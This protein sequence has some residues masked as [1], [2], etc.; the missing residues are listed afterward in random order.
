M[1]ALWT[2]FASRR[3]ALRTP[4][5]G[6][7]TI[8]DARSR[9]WGKG[10]KLFFRPF[11]MDGPQRASCPLRS[12]KC[13]TALV[14][15]G[16]LLP[17]QAM[18]AQATASGQVVS[19]KPDAIAIT[20]YN[21]DL[22]MISELRTVNLPAGRSVISFEGVS[23]RMIP[24][25]AVLQEFSGFTL[26]QNFDFNLLG[27]GSL[28]ASAIGE[29]VTLI[30]TNPKTGREKE[31]RGRIVFG[32]RGVVID[33]GDSYEALQCS[34]MPERLVFDALPEDLLARPTLSI[35]VTAEKAGPQEIR[36]G[37]L[38]SG[39][40]W[41]A[42]YRFDLNES[43]K[44]GRLTGWLTI[45]NQTAVSVENADMSA[46]AGELQ[47]LAETRAP[48]S[49]TK[50]FYANCWRRGNTKTGI[51]T[52]I[53]GFTQS[54]ARRLEKDGEVAYMMAPSAEMA[55]ADEITV[56]GSRMMRQDMKAEREDLGDYKLYRTPWPTTVAAYQTKQIMFL[57]KEQ[58]DVE[59]IHVL[60]FGGRWGSSQI[61]PTT[62]EYRVDN[63]REG[64]LA[65]PL[66]QGTWRVL[67]PLQ[68][69]GR[70]YLGENWQDNL[71]VGLPVELEI[72]QSNDVV[73]E[74]VLV[75]DETYR[76]SRE[77]TVITR[78]FE[79]KIHNAS[80]E[81]VTVEIT[82]SEEDWVPPK[83]RRQSLQRVAD[84]QRPTWQLK[85]APGEIKTLRYTVR[86][87]E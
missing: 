51:R 81:T 24:Q 58:V 6:R 9:V 29:E 63:S 72:G 31:R 11:G 23:D 17:V 53:Y 16:L 71:A 41:N 34:A 49:S 32:A 45:D 61:V 66:P 55:M 20:I 15:L 69:R 27:K 4:P 2:F 12:K 28:L 47:R 79:H 37:Y 76:T 19:Q 86:W 68:G 43:G 25:T 54:R 26:E 85:V 73:I 56:T 35:E 13:I 77:T 59:K 14:A 52:S 87:E 33:F 1:R 44:S 10:L 39:Y 84:K 50:N 83:I 67:Q 30:T 65:E 22:A 70:F 21:D 74:T 46:V 5:A 40:G 80:P 60:K 62:I 75:S 3:F 7:Q 57:D 38:T 36:L 82:E 42:N 18:A 8:A 64:K 78:S 48:E